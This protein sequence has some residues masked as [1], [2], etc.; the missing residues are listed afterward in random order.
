M[1]GDLKSDFTHTEYNFEV[2]SDKGSR[3]D[4]VGNMLIAQA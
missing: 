3:D 4:S 1:I 2:S